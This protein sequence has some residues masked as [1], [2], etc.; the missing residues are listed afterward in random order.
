[1]NRSNP[2]EKAGLAVGIL[3]VALC[4]GAPL[5]VGS[6]LAGGLGVALA[7]QGTLVLGLAA[8]VVG[9]ALALSYALRRRRAAGESPAQ[10]AA[11]PAADDCCSPLARPLRRET[12]GETHTR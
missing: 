6:L 11:E 3:A 10:P 4:C 9:A 2:G 8:V 7:G 5:L 12:R 1:M